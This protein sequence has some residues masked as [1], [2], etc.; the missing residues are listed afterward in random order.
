MASVRNVDEAPS[1]DSSNTV[2]FEMMMFYKKQAEL[3]E[4]ERA[5]AQNKY[6]TLEEEYNTLRN[7][8]S[9]LQGEHH[10]RLLDL[11]AYEVANRR[12]SEIIV[13]K[14]EAGLRMMAAFD[15]LMGAIEVTNQFH[16][17]RGE[18]HGDIRHIYERAMEEQ[19]R[20]DMAN[21]MFMTGWLAPRQDIDMTS[22]E[23]VD[24]TGE[25]TETD[26]EM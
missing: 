6:D 13:R 10:D 8:A 2:L 22:D 20:M 18:D 19:E 11:H 3:A 4:K 9:D 16:K 14:H 7:Y 1:P 17:L 25:E 5:A 12:G 24:L 26:E 21:T 23:V 15:G